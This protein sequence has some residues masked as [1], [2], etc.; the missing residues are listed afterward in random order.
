MSESQSPIFTRLASLDDAAAMAEIYNFEVENSTATMDLVPR[1]LSDQRQWI[2]DRSGAFSALVAVT[3]NGEIVGFAALSPFKERA[4]YRPTVE[5]SIYVH[6]DFARQ[7]IG[8]QLL[9]ELLNMAST[10]GFHSVMARIEASGTASQAL[11]ASLGF[12][13]VG[14][15]IEVA[16]K[17]NRWLDIVVMQRLL[18]EK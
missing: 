9:S 8:R 6:R 10:S 18:S 12:R 5:D 4:A 16:R 1:T 7:G 17:F 15:E 14:E 2:A 11:H 13:R 3:S